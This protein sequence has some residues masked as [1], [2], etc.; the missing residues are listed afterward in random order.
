MSSVRY[1]LFALFVGL[2]SCVDAIHRMNRLYT[3]YEQ[4]I[5][6]SLFRERVGI[7]TTCNGT[8]IDTGNN[9]MALRHVIL[10]QNVHDMKP[11]AKNA[12]FCTLAGVLVVSA[13]VCRAQT[14]TNDSASLKSLM[15]EYEKAGNKIDSDNAGAAQGQ[16]TMYVKE[17]QKIQQSLQ[18]A[19][20]LD[21]LNAAK[22]EL[23]RFK[24]EQTVP[25]NPDPSLPADVQQLQTLY[26]KSLAAIEL[27][28]SRKIVSAAKQYVERLNALQTRLT[29]AGR[30]DDA[31]EVNAEIKRVKA[32]SRVTGANF[33]VAAVESEK[34]SQPDEAQQ[35]DKTRSASNSS[36][37]VSVDSSVARIYEGKPF[38]SIPAG[39]K[40]E[41]YK[42]VGLVPSEA[43]PIGQ[44]VSVTATLKA[45]NNMKK[46]SS[47]YYSSTSQS[48]SGTMVYTLRVTLKSA[49]KSSVQEDPKLVV[50][51]FVKNTADSGKGDPKVFD[52]KTIPLSKIDDARAVGVEL[53]SISIDSSSSK[54]VSRYRGVIR[55]SASGNEYC[56]F[57]ISV[58]DRSGMLVAQM[59]SDISLKSLGATKLP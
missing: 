33:A 47:T 21:G 8:S 30:L 45:E 6:E 40:G 28:K 5:A 57:V 23:E 2:K 24:A 3:Y 58:F 10:W 16:A 4:V 46:S 34:Q 41:S 26:K 20:D 54:V 50:Q 49:V 11:I 32:D 44:K 39:E 35:G 18:K 37:T 22:G 48:K 12:L 42:N 19:G 53:P 31:M 27:D 25:D 59:A 1:K 55:T 15:A 52:T 43:L 51:C 38:P 56:G 9:K 17:L 14:S 29:K 13:L 36:D 7:I